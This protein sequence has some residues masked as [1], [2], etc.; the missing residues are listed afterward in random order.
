MCGSE[1]DNHGEPMQ[2]TG[3]D[4]KHGDM[5]MAIDA[6]RW[7]GRWQLHKPQLLRAV[8]MKLEHPEYSIREL[9]KFCGV[10]RSR[11]SDI[12]R[13]A[14]TIR[15]LLSAILGLEKPKARGQKQRRKQEREDHE[16]N[17]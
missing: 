7:A 16:H 4:A 6:L 2:S 15:P 8:A 1:V 13:E 14:V 10:K 17:S 12:L 3:N 11:L 9:E 5:T